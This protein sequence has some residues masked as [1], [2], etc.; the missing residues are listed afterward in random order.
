[1]DRIACFNRPVRRGL[2]AA[3][4]G[5]FV[6]CSVAFGQETAQS[7]TKAK[8]EAIIAKA[9]QQLGGDK[10]LQIRSTIG[11]GKFSVLRDG[12]VVSYQTFVDIIAFPD[13]ERTEFKGG[14]TR[15]IQVNTGS[16]GWIYDDELKV[17]RQ[18]TEVQVANFK[19]GMRTSL[20][21][22][23][24]GYWRGE[25][26]LSY[27]GRRPA[28]LGK[29]NDVIKLTYKDGFTVEFEF[30]DD[31]LPQKALY[32]RKTIEG[33]DLKEED[34]YAQFI[35]LNGIRSPMIVDRFTDAH[36][37]SRINYE[38]IEYNRTIPD[39]IF[40]KPANA[41]EAKKSVKY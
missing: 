39:A 41:K 34:R 8:A 17:I 4:I 7:D 38:S 32:K 6:F 22:V 28:T 5:V 12:G 24:R 36:A 40:A 1:M 19:M 11:R 14:G 15:T 20:D 37:S 9:I 16:M 21:N 23:L 2:R 3:F 26:D 13:R 25:A 33:D 27:V 10:Y 30:A 35:E 29:R 18:Q 31:G